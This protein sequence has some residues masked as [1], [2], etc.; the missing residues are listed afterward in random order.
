[1]IQ[2]G[3]LITYVEELN[4]TIALHGKPNGT[5]E[6]PAPSCCYLKENYGGVESG[7][8]PLVGWGGDSVTVHVT[9]S[10]LD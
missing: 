3:W 1:M 4:T 9:R 2:A 5:K 6:F 8:I 10:I 7:M